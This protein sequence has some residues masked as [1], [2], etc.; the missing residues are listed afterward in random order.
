MTDQTRI[1]PKHVEG[2]VDETILG[3]KVVT[4]HFRGGIDRNGDKSPYPPAGEVLKMFP[5]SSSAGYKQS[6]CLRICVLQHDPSMWRG[7]WMRLFSAGKWL[8][9]ISEVALTGMVIF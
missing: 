5:L 2:L 7:L 3:G 4:D 6:R 8:R 9:T 1:E